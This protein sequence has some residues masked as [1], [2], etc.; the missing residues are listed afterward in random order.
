MHGIASDIRPDVVSE[1]HATV[2]DAPHMLKTQEGVDSQHQL[3]SFA[4]APSVTE[5]T[6]TV[7]KIQT[8][9]A[10]RSPFTV[11]GEVPPPPPQ[12]FFGRDELIEQVVGFAQNLTPIALIG[13]GG[14]GKTSI[15]LTI[16]HDDRIKQRFGDNRWFIRCDQFSASRAH[17]LHRL[18]KAIGAGIENPRRVASLRRYLSSKEMIIVLDNAES[19][20]DPRGPG[21]REIHA[22]VDELTRFSNVCLCVTSRISTIPRSCKALGVLKFSVAAAHDTFYHIYKHSERCDLINDILERLNFHPLSITLL[23]TVAQCN[24]WSGNRLAMEW[25]RQRAGTLRAQRPGSLATAIELSLSSSMFQ[26][27]GPDARALLEVVAFFPQG[28]DEENVDWLFSTVSDAPKMLNTFCILSVA[29]RSNGFIMMLAPLWDYFYPKD[30][31]TSPLLNTV[32]ERY[33]TRLSTDIDPD[34]P[35]H[36]GSRWITSEDV[37]V[38]HLLDVFTSLDPSSDVIWDACAGFLYHLNRHKPRVTILSPK[39]KALS[40]NNP[41]KAQCLRALA[42]WSNSAGSRKES[43]RLH[44]KTLKLWRKSGDARQVAKT[45]LYLC[46]TDRALGLGGESMQQA[47]EALEIFERLGDTVKQAKCFI[48]LGRASY[49]DGELDAAEEA[50]LRAIELLPENGQQYLVCQGHR[51][52]GKVYTSEGE[53]KKAAHHFEIALGAATTLGLPDVLFWVHVEMTKM[54]YKQ[55]AFE[56]AHDYIERA[57]LYAHNAYNL[58]RAMELRASIYFR[59]GMFEKARFEASCAVDAYSRVE[60]KTSIE[61]CEVLL[62]LIDKSILGDS[63]KLLQTASPPVCINTSS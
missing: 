18:S 33:F 34:E 21:A 5:Y 31:A 41:S 11:T 32:K 53:T 47:W 25:E 38:E 63:G 1:V 26:E 60:I 43:K 35:D 44:T 9:P 28:V 24:K 40:D 51:L 39:I 4:C 57:K 56:A 30:P 23:A 62:K 3:V 55:S 61:R 58:G 54:F 17:L 16:L 12:I 27:L 29:Y 6:F 8:G 45:F 49:D 48:R 14:I 59:Q 22:A 2:S 36:E 20:L 19:I 42:L 10:N 50:A 52:L 37:N 13:A 15:A 7:P 46:D